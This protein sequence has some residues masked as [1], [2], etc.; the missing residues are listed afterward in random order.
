MVALTPVNVGTAVFNYVVYWY[1]SY[2][3]GT[4]YTYTSY[5]TPYYANGLFQTTG[6]EWFDSTAGD[7]CSV[8]MKVYATA[9]DYSDCTDAN[10]NAVSAPTLSWSGSTNWSI[11]AY[12]GKWC[13]SQF[14]FCVKCIRSSIA[15]FSKPFQIVSR[16]TCNFD[17]S[18]WK[19]DPVPHIFVQNTE[20][21]GTTNHYRFSFS[22]SDYV[23][24]TS[25]FYE[26]CEF[27]DTG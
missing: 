20:N 19:A 12:Y 21:T 14:F 1:Y 4:R 13:D 7:S 6:G 2:Y 11:S 27:V 17:A 24:N 3:S 23:I 5:I 8:R 26:K 18:I 16:G 22:L 25:C 15:F 9:F 10:T